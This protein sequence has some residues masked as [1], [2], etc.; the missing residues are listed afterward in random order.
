MAILADLTR[1]RRE[2]IGEGLWLGGSGGALEAFVERGRR[3]IELVPTRDLIFAVEGDGR[4]GL[5]LAWFTPK[6]GYHLRDVAQARGL[7]ADVVDILRNRLRWCITAHVVAPR[8]QVSLAGRQVTVILS[9]RLA[10]ELR[11][12]V[13]DLLAWPG[14]SPPRQ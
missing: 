1:D 13:I 11:R 12:L 5:D 14:T 6:G 7:A 2:A 8:R 4:D 3:P 9:E 10:A